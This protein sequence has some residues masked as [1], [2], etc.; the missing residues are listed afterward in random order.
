MGGAGAQRDARSARARDSSWARW[1]CA[2]G[3]GCIWPF[4]YVAGANGGAAFPVIYVTCVALVGIPVMR[5]EFA[6]GKPAGDLLAAVMLFAME[7][8]KW[9]GRGNRAAEARA[10]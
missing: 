9:L 8:H 1:G 6:L 3:V 10:S 7:A 2:V 4:A 5:A